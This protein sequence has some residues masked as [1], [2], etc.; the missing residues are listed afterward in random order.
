M[1]RT[2]RVEESVAIARPPAEVW[3][4]IA[5]YGFDRERRKGLRDMT[6]DPPGP[7]ALGTKA[8]EVVRAAG[9]DYVADT[10][11]TELDPGESYR[12]AG[13]GTIGALEGGRAVRPDEAG[14]GA[15]FTYAIELQPTRGMRALGP[16]LEDGRRV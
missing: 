15:V 2:I 12:F 13:T 16:L 10:E 11:V 8:H 7:P 4:A 9:R 3:S 14:T 6:P 1:G 5:D